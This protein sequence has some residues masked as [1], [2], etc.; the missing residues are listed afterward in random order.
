MTNRFSKS[1]PRRATPDAVNLGLARLASFVRSSRDFE[2]AAKHVMLLDPSFAPLLEPAHGKESSAHSSS[3]ASTISRPPPSRHQWTASSRAKSLGAP[4]ALLIRQR[5]HFATVSNAPFERVANLIARADQTASAIGAALPKS[6]DAV[7]PSLNPKTVNSFA[8]STH[9]AL[10]QSTRHFLSIKGSR[11]E[12]ELANH[13]QNEN[14]HVHSSRMES[15]RAATNTWHVTHAPQITVVI[16]GAEA[17]QPGKI[18]EQM[19][20]ALQSHHSELDQK[21]A[22]VWKRQAVRDERTKF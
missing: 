10:K 7:T 6:A 11:L 2:R 3:S 8:L 9:P 12:S 13:L 20:M 22:D 15:H 18:A 5:E 14:S 4:S 16:N 21:L 19:V 1:E 17:A